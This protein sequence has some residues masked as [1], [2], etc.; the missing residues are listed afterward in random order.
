MPIMDRLSLIDA[1]GVPDALLVTQNPED[2]RTVT[3]VDVGEQYLWFL[4]INH[5]EVSWS[6]VRIHNVV[7]V[8]YSEVVTREIH[9]SPSSEDMA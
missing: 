3:I 8:V 4:D 1:I 7:K 6:R 5:P 2:S 9:Q